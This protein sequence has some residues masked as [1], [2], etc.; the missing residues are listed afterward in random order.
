[1]E[2]CFECSGLDSECKTFRYGGND[3]CLYYDI[4]KRDL[5]RL[6]VGETNTVTLGNM[7]RDYLIN[8]G[9]KEEALKLI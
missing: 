9:R 8:N 6:S 2:N 3:K 5:A 1:M 4:A 7:L